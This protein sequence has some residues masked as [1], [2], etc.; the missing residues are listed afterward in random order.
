MNDSPGVFSPWACISLMLLLV[1]SPIYAQQVT[2]Q[3]SAAGALKYGEPNQQSRVEPI[4]IED[5]ELPAFIDGTSFVLKP[6]TYYLDR[7]R[8]SRPDNVGWALGGALEYKSGWWQKKFRA[9]ATLYTSQKLYGPSD[10]DGTLLF[11]PGPDAFTVLGEANIT[12]RF[13]ENQGIRFG[14]QRFELPYLGSHDIRMVPN[15][16]EAIAV[17]NKSPTGLAYIAGYVD[18][19]KRKNDD[20]FIAMSEAAG[21]T[22][23]DK[24]VIFAAARYAVKDGMLAGATYQQTPDVFDTFFAKIEHPFSTGSGA[25]IKGF[26]QYT[27]QRSIGDERIGEFDTSLIAG[28][29]ELKDGDTTWRVALST[30][31][32]NSGIQKP[33]GNP[34]NYLSVIVDDFDRA[35]EDAWLVGLSYDFKRVAIGDMSMFANVVSGNT[36]DSGVNASPDETEYDVTVDYRIKEGW[37]NKLWL[38]VRAAYIDQDEDVGGDD[39]LDFRI[40]ANYEF[41]ML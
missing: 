23:N 24:G 10:K 41:D 21:A 6:R 2:E 13:A 36:P 27:S 38:R 19:I 9:A 29:L 16:F 7:N 26:L 32:E 8:D 12:W 35:G 5:E 34:A 22:G 14:R 20:E 3:P 15:T 33:Y 1:C 28:K 37:A 11:K 30:T 31:D 39:F 40:I 18:S 17:G 25:N 4:A